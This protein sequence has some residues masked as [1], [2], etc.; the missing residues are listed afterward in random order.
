[1][2]INSGYKLKNGIILPCIGLGAYKL[3]DKTVSSVL[4]AL[5][6]GYRMIDTASRYENEAEVGEAVRK[7]GIPREEIFITTKVWNEDQRNH[8]QREAFEASL[9]RL[10]MDYVDMYMVHWAIEGRFVETWKILLDLY[11]QKRVRVIGVCNF[12]IPHLEELWTRTGVL[13]MVNQI[14]I[15]PKNTRKEL[16]AWCKAHG[17]QVE[18]WAP[19]GSGMVLGLPELAEIAAR[20]GRTPAQVILRWDL[21]NGI[22]V[23]PRSTSPERIAQN[24]DIFDFELT[25]E[26]MS[27]IDALNENWINP[28]SGGD[29]NNVTF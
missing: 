12:E 13:P 16:I 4:A 10:G 17:I 29:P 21:Q 2:D 26:E 19:L 6:A 9:Q 18:A 14:E 27:A 1:M 23:I 8:T 24:A 15:H 5:A 22:A 25:D 3:G 7:S 11:E 20:H 28:L